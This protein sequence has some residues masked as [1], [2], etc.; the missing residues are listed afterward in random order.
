[1][2]VNVDVVAISMTVDCF[3]S[4]DL[5]SR[6]VRVRFVGLGEAAF[7]LRLEWSPSGSDEEDGKAIESDRLESVVSMKLCSGSRS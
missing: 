6:I 4:S 7:C 2:A 3:P 1:M 5:L